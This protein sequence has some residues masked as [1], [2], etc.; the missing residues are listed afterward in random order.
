MTVI[1]GPQPVIGDRPDQGSLAVVGSAANGKEWLMA[2][3][4]SIQIR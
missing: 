4:R 3:M 1:N 2:M